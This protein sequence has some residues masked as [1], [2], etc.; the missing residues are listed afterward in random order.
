MGTIP[1]KELLN[2][3]EQEQLTVDVATRHTLQHLESLHKT[4]KQANIQR[5]QIITAL[6][7]IQTS[8]RSLRHDVDALIAHTS[9]PLRKA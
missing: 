1:A 8:L 7:E 5:Q 9:M 3:W 6:G 4:D 2:Q